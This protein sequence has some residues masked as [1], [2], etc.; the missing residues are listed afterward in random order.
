MARLPGRPGTRAHEPIP[1]LPAR[2]RQPRASRAAGGQHAV[3]GATSSEW[4]A[5]ADRPATAAN[6]AYARLKALIL[7]N[8]LA[9]GSQRLESELAAEL[10]LS[11]TPVRE[12]MVRLEQ[13]GLVTI[14]PRHGMRVTAVTPAD[15]REIYEVLN[16][17][18][19]AA[20]ELLT[21]RGLAAK[22]L[23]PLADAC[24]AMERALHKE[25]RHAWAAAD[26]VFH[27]GLAELCGNRRLA[28]MIMQVWDQSHRARMFT[29]HQ[30]PLPERST[31]EH[32]AV[33][34]AVMAGDS[35]SAREMY[36]LHRR[37]S[38]EELIALIERSG[39]AWL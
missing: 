22:Q 19:P 28:G 12:A 35:E 2:A 24:T 31:A 11:R 36:R 16:S 8:A 17:L 27:L 37:R 39:V 5:D 18:E 25:D 14:T 3:Q 1:P 26:E 15:M 30:R 10:G 6:L 4:A 9:P 23:A 13:D 21:R 7:D 34:Q 29:L 38:G 33:L 20:A 32:R